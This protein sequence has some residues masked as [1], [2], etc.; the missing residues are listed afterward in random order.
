VAVL[1]II[2]GV[3]GGDCGGGVN[4]IDIYRVGVSVIY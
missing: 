4:W 2:V 1:D 3:D